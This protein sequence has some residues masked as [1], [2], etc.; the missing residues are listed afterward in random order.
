[1]KDKNDMIVLIRKEESL[2]MH[3][4]SS[5]LKSHHRDVYVLDC[6]KAGL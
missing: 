5:L 6:Y 1:M 3:A 4:S 2:I